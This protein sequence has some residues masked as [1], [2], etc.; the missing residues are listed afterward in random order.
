MAPDKKRSYSKGNPAGTVWR[1]KVLSYSG[2][3]CAAEGKRLDE[4]D[5]HSG[6]QGNGVSLLGR[7]QRTE[8]KRR[9]YRRGKK[10]RGSFAKRKSIRSDARG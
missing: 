5:V 2:V 10:A 1:K 6:L 3:V 4:E 7:Y 8:G 9:L